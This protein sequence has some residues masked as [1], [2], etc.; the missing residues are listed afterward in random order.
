MAIRDQVARHSDYN[1]T[2]DFIPTP[3][4]ATRALY[5]HVA[6]ELLANAHKWT[7]YDPAAG[8]GHMLRVFSEYWHADSFGT[9][10]EPQ[11]GIA[12]RD[13]LDGQDERVYESDV[14]ITNPPYKFFNEFV[15]KSLQEAEE[16]VAMLCRVQT[17]EGQRRFASLYSH[18]PPTQIAFFSDR[19]PFKVGSVVRKAPKMFFHVW[20]WWNK[21]DLAPRPPLWI[22]PTVQRDLEKDSDYE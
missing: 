21:R 1:E 8:H 13:F 7:A 16:G 5:E 10:I 19:I 17:L 9:D 4:F 11:P 15:L 14:I 22:P 3:P 6:P 2:R 18:Q 12:K 20:L